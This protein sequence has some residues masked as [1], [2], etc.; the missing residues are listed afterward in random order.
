MYCDVPDYFNQNTLVILVS[1]SVPCTKNTLI[2]NMAPKKLG[3]LNK[4]ADE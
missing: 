1:V 2:K 3:A 4:Q